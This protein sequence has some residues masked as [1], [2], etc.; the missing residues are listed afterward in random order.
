MTTAVARHDE[1]EEEKVYYIIKVLQQN[2]W[3]HEKSFPWC[4]FFL[5]IRLKTEMKKNCAKVPCTSWK[6]KSG[7]I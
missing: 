1:G 4:L 3:K 7:W 6:Y 2:E 5:Q